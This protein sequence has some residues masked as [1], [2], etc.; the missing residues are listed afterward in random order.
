M[1]MHAPFVC[2]PNDWVLSISAIET[3]L[4]EKIIDK[5]RKPHIDDDPIRYNREEK[6]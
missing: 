5:K 6:I 2:W 3:I 1:I 4:P